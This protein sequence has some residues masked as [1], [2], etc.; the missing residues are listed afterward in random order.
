VKK[1]GILRWSKHGLGCWSSAPPVPQL[2]CS[3]EK[4][5]FP[6]LGP[7]LDGKNFKLIN[8]ISFVLFD[9]YYPIID[10]LGSKDSYRDFQLNCTISYFFLPTFNTL[11]K[12]LKIDVMERVKKLRIWMTS[13]RGLG[14]GIGYEILLL[15][16]WPSLC[17]AASLG[18][19]VGAEKHSTWPGSYVRNSLLP[20]AATPLALG[21]LG[22]RW[23]R[24]GPRLDVI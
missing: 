4:A 22:T 11:Y 10:Q 14:I 18:W 2:F 6:R 16:K 9:K 20:H 8:S 21:R 17:S 23:E 5:V 1:F 7:R 13:K 15:C 24:P 19:I 3:P 12:R